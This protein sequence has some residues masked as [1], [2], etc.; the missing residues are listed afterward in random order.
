VDNVICHNSHLYGDG[1][2]DS[3]CNTLGCTYDVICTF[4]FRMTHGWCLPP[5]LISPPLL[6]QAFDFTTPC[7]YVKRHS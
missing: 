6:G 1:P 2:S 5:L 3:T 4:L 7:H